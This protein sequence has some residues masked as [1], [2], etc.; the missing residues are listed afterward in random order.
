MD[1]IKKQAQQAADDFLNNETQY[2]LGFIE[3]EQSNPITKTV[4]QTF[5][6]NT[7]AGVR[8]LLQ[9]DEALACT[10]EK[11]VASES[12]L[13]LKK[14]I[15]QALTGGGRILLSGCGSSGRL[16]FAV[17][18][19]WR[20]AIQKM[21]CKYP[22][23]AQYEDRVQTIMTGGDFTIIRSVESFED[24]TVVSENQTRLFLPSAADLLIGVT[25]TAETTSVFQA[26]AR[27]R[28][29]ESSRL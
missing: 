4:G 15:A 3:A 26:P 19:C 27:T 9:V 21:S 13:L 12:F 20:T 18:A 16:S 2:R 8:M 17:E 1:E 28:S 25:A 29:L 23:L 24:S 14:Q 10:F 22:Q 6:K 5:R 11:S 7:A